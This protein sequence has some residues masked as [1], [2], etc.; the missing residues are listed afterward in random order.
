MVRVIV[1]VPGLVLTT[2]QPQTLP[3]FGQA[4]FE[5]LMGVLE[6]EIAVPVPLT[7]LHE[8][9][10]LPEQRPTE[11]LQLCGLSMTMD[12]TEFLV[13]V[14]GQPAAGEIR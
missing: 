2:Y 14:V 9:M 7:T 11:R 4:T 1:Q 6:D 8:L 10:S 13:G 3:S 5:S 12:A